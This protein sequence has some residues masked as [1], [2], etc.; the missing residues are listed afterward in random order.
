M[1]GTS[2]QNIDTYDVEVILHTLSTCE[3]N[4]STVFDF[5][6]DDN[7]DVIEENMYT[8]KEHYE[9]RK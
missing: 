1:S 4:H 6:T 5:E 2:N 3:E 7:Y 9:I 8:D